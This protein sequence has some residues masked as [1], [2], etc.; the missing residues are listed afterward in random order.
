MT[1]KWQH[2]GWG[3]V[4][5]GAI[6]CIAVSPLRFSLLCLL[7]RPSAIADIQA[8]PFWFR[9]PVCIEGIV[10][11]RAPIVDGQLYQLKDATGSMWIV[12]PDTGLQLGQAI[13]IKGTLQFQSIVIEGQEQGELYIE[14]ST[15]AQL[16]P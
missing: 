2:W 12:S 14:Q 8:M 11:D 1:V 15:P 10:G 5:M 13:K 4:G 6:A 16:T 9:L 3:I 7:N